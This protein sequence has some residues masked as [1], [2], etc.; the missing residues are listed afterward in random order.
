M[1]TIRKLIALTTLLLSMFSLNAQGS[2]VIML[3]DNS[4]SI[5][6]NEYSQMKTFCG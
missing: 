1:N 5:S 6:N 4:G 3:L 2:D